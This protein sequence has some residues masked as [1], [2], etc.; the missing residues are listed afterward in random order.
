[1]QVKVKRS[2]NLALPPKSI[3]SNL[4]LMEEL[5]ARSSPAEVV[6]EISA[7]AMRQLESLND[8]LEETLHRSGNPSLSLV[9]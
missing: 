4:P 3:S 7:G 2:T 1:M 6:G 8:D 9:P 5:S